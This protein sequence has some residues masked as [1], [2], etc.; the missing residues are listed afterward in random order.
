[1]TKYLVENH[2]HAYYFTDVRGSAAIDYTSI[3]TQ[4]PG[5]P[6]VYVNNALYG[7]ISLRSRNSAATKRSY[8]QDEESK[9]TIGSSKVITYRF[10]YAQVK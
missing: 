7:W 9:V 2:I 1:M 5:H 6:Y 3:Q 10:V 8:G 4:R